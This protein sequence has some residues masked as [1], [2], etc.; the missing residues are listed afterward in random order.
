MSKQVDL[1]AYYDREKYLLE[2]VGP[3]YRRTGELAAEDFFTIVAWK[4]E[5][6]KSKVARRLQTKAGSDLREAVAKLARAI[7]LSEGWEE[8]LWVVNEEW[9]LRLPMA[10]AVLSILYPDQFSV[11]D[12]RVC[13]ELSISPGIADLVWR[14]RKERY[15]E[16][17]ERVDAEVPGPMTLRDK[18]RVLWARSVWKQ[19]VDDIDH[20]FDST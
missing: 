13:Q 1:L 12:V 3:A 11:F 18:D 20:G 4:A 10:S 14:N 17:L 7:H 5:R 2:H 16:Y 6:A 8:K 15:R 9:G 19:L